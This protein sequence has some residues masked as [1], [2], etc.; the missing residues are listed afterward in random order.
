MATLM[1]SSA[2]VGSVRTGGKE[3]RSFVEVVFG[4]FGIARVQQNLQGFME[5]L[6][7]NG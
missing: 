1:N 3:G 4:L 7:P 6:H 2:N 5:G